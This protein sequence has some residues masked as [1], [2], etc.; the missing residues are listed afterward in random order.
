MKAMGLS[1]IKITWKPCLRVM[2]RLEPT[3]CTK[4]GF[5]LTLMHFPGRVIIFEGQKNSFI[6][7][8][9]KHGGSSLDGHTFILQQEEMGTATFS[10][11]LEW[12]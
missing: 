9:K 5:Q 3:R 7:L 4:V 12:K 6:K 1:N 10:L 8:K 2:E 11:S